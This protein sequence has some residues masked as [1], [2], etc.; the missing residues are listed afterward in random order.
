[1]KEIYTGSL[2]R[3]SAFDPEEMGKAYAEWNRDSEFKR[4]LDS[5]AARLHSAKSG[6]DFFQKML[7]EATAANHF[8]AIRTL[9]DN[10]LLGDIGLDVVNNWMGRNAFVGIAIG[11]REDWSKGY[12]TDAMTLLLRYAF[13]EINL[14]RVTL[15]VFE[16][17][18]RAI[19]AY[20]KAG[21]THEGRLRGALLRDGKRWDMLSMGVLR[22][23]WL[24]AH[25]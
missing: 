4:L 19:R 25:H 7:D 12:G 17:N 8:F 18:P 22:E 9:S 3:L 14:N 2:V 23:D 11:K 16:Y 15:C 10:R 6:A 1:M 20:E 24:A 13:A 21:F 5:D